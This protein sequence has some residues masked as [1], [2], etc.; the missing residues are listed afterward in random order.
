M[1]ISIHNI[2]DQKTFIVEMA[3]AKGACE[4]Q[5]ARLLAAQT[6]E[7]ALAVVWQNYGWLKTHTDIRIREL[8]S[9][10]QEQLAPFYVWLLETYCLGSNSAVQAV[11]DLHKRVIAGDFPT[12]AAW[13]AAARSAAGAATDA[14][15]SAA[16]RS[17]AARSAAARSVDAWSAACAADAAVRAEIWQ[18]LC[19]Q[20]FEVYS[21]C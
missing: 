12:N 19:Q 3:K 20:I 21:K 1:E 15:W 8:D 2:S 10:T 11:I 5:P 13:S 7:E 17:A 6:L 9:L 14:A 4:S 18:K 16:A